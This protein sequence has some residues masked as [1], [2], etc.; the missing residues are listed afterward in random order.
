MQNKILINSI[1]KNILLFSPFN[2]ISW[3]IERFITRFFFLFIIYF[4]TSIKAKI[5][6]IICYYN[7]YIKNC[8]LN[9]YFTDSMYIVV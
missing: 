1:C 2:I 6:I 8:N 7:T 9:Y 4:I 3:R 5:K